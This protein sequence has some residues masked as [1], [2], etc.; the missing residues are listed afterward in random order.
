MACRL[1]ASVYRFVITDDAGMIITTVHGRGFHRVTLPIG[2]MYHVAV[3]NQIPYYFYS[4]MQDDGNMRGPSL[5]VDSRETGW[6]HAMGGCESGFTVPDL[7]DPDVVWATCYGD[8]VTRWDARNKHARSVSPWRSGI[9]DTPICS[10]LTDDGEISG[11]GTRR[12]R[13]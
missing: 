4:N 3:D 7:T 5:P 12:F 9:F 2:Q 6:D 11:E 13:T 8:T 1:S 10:I